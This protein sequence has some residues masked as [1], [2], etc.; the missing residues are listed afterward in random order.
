MIANAAVRRKQQE[1]ERKYMYAA[2]AAQQ[3]LKTGLLTEAT[4]Q[5]AR[6]QQATGSGK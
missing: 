1:V 6:S 2:P 3:L 4:G 5:Q